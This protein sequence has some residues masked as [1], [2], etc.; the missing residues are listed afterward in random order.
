MKDR[1]LKARLPRELYCDLQARAA[2]AGQR[3]GTYVREVLERDA[4]AIAT[5]QVLARIEAALAAA[6]ASSASPPALARDHELH[7]EVFELRLIV[8]E[9][10][11]HTNAQILTRVAAQLIAQASPVNPSSRST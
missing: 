6:P 10:A 8:R 2:E 7:R 1:Y 5:E 11:M 3:L 4:Q 9:L